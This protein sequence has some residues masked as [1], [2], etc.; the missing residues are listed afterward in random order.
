MAATKTI[1]IKYDLDG[2]TFTRDV[3][4]S[5]GASFAIEETIPASSTDL[6]IVITC[7]VS[8]VKYFAIEAIDGDM[9]VEVNSSSAPDKTFT[10][11]AD[12]P[13][14]WYTGC[15]HSQLAGGTDWTTAYV[16]SVQ[17]GTLRIS[18]L[19]DPTV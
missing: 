9:T 11:T 19:Y 7:D 15:G 1:T 10:L 4:I 6:Q 16:T 18:G 2:Q 5:A 3:Q 17:G 12:V 8:Q 14:V 13:Q